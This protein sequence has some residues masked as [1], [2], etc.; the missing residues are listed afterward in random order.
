MTF[1]ITSTAFKEM[2]TIP[3]KYSCE[4]E[5]VNPPLLISNVPQDAK[6]LALIMD[7]K[8][9]TR[10]VF[11]HWVAFNLPPNTKEIKEGVLPQGSVQGNN[12]AG[13]AG[14]VGPC[15]PPGKIHHYAFY[16]YALN[17]LLSLEVGAS[18]EEVE[19][20]L[21]GHIIAQA[22]LTGIFER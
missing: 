2:Q 10:G 11:I 3:K 13:K 6:S 17:T 20:A 8:D 7:D 1:Q 15:P 9:A 22:K 4:G 12:S 14:Y 16:L 21:A 5:Q 18:K 19:Q